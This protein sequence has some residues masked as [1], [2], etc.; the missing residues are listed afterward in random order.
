MGHTGHV[1]TPG[2][3]GI[4]TVI[5]R[6]VEGKKISD[7]IY[8]TLG[9]TNFVSHLNKPVDLSKDYPRKTLVI[10]FFTT[11]PSASSDKLTYH[12]AHIQ[13]GF[14]LKKHDTSI[15]MIS[16][17]VNPAVDS[18]AAMRAYANS[19]TLDHDT[20]TFITASQQE[21]YRV[22]KNE[23]FLPNAN[24]L[25]KNE[26]PNEIILIDKYRNIRG[27]YNG[28]DSSQVKKCIDDV[29]IMMVEK[30][31]IHEKKSRE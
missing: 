26:V 25:L 21:L 3:F 8:H 11:A 9:T 16:I 15:Q 13:E 22:A 19:H 4:D 10:N 31:K 5:E 20:W 1:Y 14:K 29:A 6:T 27:Y 23:L 18:V 30:N 24:R 2:N 7:T 28:L 12:I 17:G